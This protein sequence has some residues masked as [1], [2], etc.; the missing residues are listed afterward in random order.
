[1]LRETIRQA[2]EKGIIKSKAIIV[3]FFLQSEAAGNFLSYTKPLL[4]RKSKGFS[5]SL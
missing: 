5:A 2:I 4:S 1:M 3:L